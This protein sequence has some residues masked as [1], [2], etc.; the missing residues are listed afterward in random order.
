MI[1]LKLT[2]ER[3]NVRHDATQGS[4]ERFAIAESS[5]SDGSSIKKN[6]LSFKLNTL[7]D[8]GIGETHYWLDSGSVLG[9]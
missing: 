7:G 4:P 5:M 1:H 9:K 2:M 3:G 8:S 6:E